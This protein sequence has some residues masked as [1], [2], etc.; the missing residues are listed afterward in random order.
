MYCHLL[1]GIWVLTPLW[2]MT[3]RYMARHTWLHI[4]LSQLRILL[5]IHTSHRHAVQHL[6]LNH[7]LPLLHYS[8]LML[9]V[10]IRTHIGVLSL[11][12][13]LLLKHL[14]I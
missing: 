3:L 12:V 8:L 6:L 7:H 2:H 1:L 11:H 5:R 10:K 9:Y 14:R 4:T 13:S